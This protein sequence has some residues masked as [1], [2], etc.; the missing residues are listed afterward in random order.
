MQAPAAC[1]WSAMWCWS[2]RR[3]DA[4]TAA[5]DEMVAAAVTGNTSGQVARR[6]SGAS[7]FSHLVMLIM[8]KGRNGMCIHQCQTR[9]PL[10]AH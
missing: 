5:K 10:P 4:I 9:F 3:F 7:I 2:A 6:K 8:C 1:S